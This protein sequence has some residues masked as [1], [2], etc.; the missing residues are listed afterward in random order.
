MSKSMSS[1]PGRPQCLVGL[2]STQPCG[3]RFL[4]IKSLLSNAS[5]FLRYLST[6]LLFLLPSQTH[7]T[8]PLAVGLDSVSLETEVSF[9]TK[10]VRSRISTS[11]DSQP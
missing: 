3:I 7:I 10:G 1:L 9:I 8:E 2:D 5:S 11:R 4:Y 6:L